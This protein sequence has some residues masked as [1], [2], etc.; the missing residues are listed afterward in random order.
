MRVPQRALLLT[1][2]A[3]AT[4]AVAGRP[5]AAQTASD[6]TKPDRFAIRLGAYFPTNTKIKSQVDSTFPAGGVDF[7][8]HQ[9]GPNERT[10][11]SIDFMDRDNHGAKEELIP[12]TLGQ[13]WYE[14]DKAQR[15]SDLYFGFGLGAYF[16]NVDVNDDQGFPHTNNQ[17]LFGGYVN[18]GLDI[19]DGIF[20]DA[21]FHM[22]NTEGPANPGGLELAAGYR[23]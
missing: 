6:T 2:A 14:T 20:I 1:L 16:A 21:R 7:T 4:F 15:H 11:A 22:T 10:I 8:L 9:I 18:A 3:C 19:Y 13:Q 12:L 23:F 17:T 5:A